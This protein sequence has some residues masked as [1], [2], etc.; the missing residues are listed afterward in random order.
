MASINDTESSGPNVGNGKTNEDNDSIP[1]IDPNEFNGTVTPFKRK[2]GRPRKST[3]ESGDEN[4]GNDNTANDIAG[5]STDNSTE[6]RKSKKKS[7][8]TLTILQKNLLMAHNILAKML[9]DDK[10]KLTVTESAEL[11]EPVFNVLDQYQFVPDPKTAAW[12]ALIMVLV[13]VYGSRIM[14]SKK[15]SKKIDD[16]KVTN[17]NRQNFPDFSGANNG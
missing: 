9:D 8:I 4:T 15:Q 3:T 12:G 14:E 5:G 6:P 17:L 7:T 1:R 2:V 13:S 11:A 16:V 10:W